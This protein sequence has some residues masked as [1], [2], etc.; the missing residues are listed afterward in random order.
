MDQIRVTSSSPHW[1][2]DEEQAAP[3]A[4]T[5]LR[6]DVHDG[7]SWIGLT[8]FETRE[9]GFGYGHPMP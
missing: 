3:R 6:P 8:A 9:A 4:P 5:G 1:R 2:A 7:P